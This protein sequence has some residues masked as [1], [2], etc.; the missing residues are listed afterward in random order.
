MKRYLI[1]G[2]G[3][4][5]AS[6]AA[7]FELNG[8]PYRLF[9]RGEQIR[10]IQAHGIRYVRP[11]G[12][13][14]IRLQACVD[15]SELV[16]TQDDLLIFTTK[17][18]DLELACADWAWLPVPGDGPARTA[19]GLPVLTPQNG[20]A[21]ERIALR[22]FG[23]VI[24]ASINTPARFTRLG[25]IVVG[26]YPEPGLIVTGRFPAGA[27]PVADGIAADLER[28]GYLAESRPDI[29]R[30]KAAKLLNSV[31]NNALDL[32]DGPPARLQ[33]FSQHLLQE[34]LAVLA[35]MGLEPARPQERRHS[36]AHWGIAPGCGIEPGQQST[37][38]SL[39]RGSSHEVDFLIGEVMLLGRLHGVP[40]PFNAAIQQA[41]GRLAQPGRMP[42]DGQLGHVDDL[43]RSA[44]DLASHLR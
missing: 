23:H 22:W 17:T 36:V 2:A 8:I 30:W 16:L 14:S 34:A 13:R 32:F 15:R 28:A 39:A 42:P 35:A 4:I 27:D 18:Q 41:V 43:W 37:W 5:G 31:R 19:S 6:L 21:A 24:G 3:A 11:E 25:E 29:M 7:Q 10:H 38:Q 1:I 12:T 44:E 20:M 9:G 33:G 40:T 26:G